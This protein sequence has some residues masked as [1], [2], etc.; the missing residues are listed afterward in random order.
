MVNNVKNVELAPDGKRVAALMP[1]AAP[2]DP[3]TQ[4]HV[5]FLLNFFDELDRRV[6]ARK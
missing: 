2:E 1:V 6:P 4:N 3:S 5:T